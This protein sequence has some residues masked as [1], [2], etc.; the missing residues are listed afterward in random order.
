MPQLG[1]GR[2]DNFDDELDLPDI[3]RV[4]DVLV[5]PSP[6]HRANEQDWLDNRRS[7]LRSISGAESSLSDSIRSW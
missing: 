1:A 5:V 3:A 6:G 4:R 2:Q 7:K